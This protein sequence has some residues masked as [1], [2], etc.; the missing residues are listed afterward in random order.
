MT[1]RKILG[2]LLLIPMSLIALVLFGT[3]LY[4]YFKFYPVVTSIVVLLIMT[5]AGFELLKEKK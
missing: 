5:V 3:I 1:P 4:A 2:M